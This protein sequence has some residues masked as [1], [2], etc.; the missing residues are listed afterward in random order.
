MFICCEISPKCEKIIT[1]EYIIYKK[2]PNF[3]GLK[4]VVSPHLDSNVSLVAFFQLVFLLF[5][6]VLKTFHH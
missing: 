2:L 1:R 3:K 6:N 5:K 4:K